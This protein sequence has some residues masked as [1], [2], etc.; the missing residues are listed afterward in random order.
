[1]KGVRFALAAMV[2]LVQGTMALADEARGVYFIQPK[3]GAVVTNPVHVKMG[4]HGM[5]VEPAGEL[6]EGAGHFHLI[7]DG[8]YVPEGEVVPKDETHLHF[9]KGQRETDLMLAPGKHTLTLQFAD[10]H[11]V[12]Y[13]KPWSQTI[14]IEVKALP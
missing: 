12:S 7:I 13:G 3:D 4:I 8:T 2:F 1:M 6:R 11:H 5:K 10:G 14:R 9:G